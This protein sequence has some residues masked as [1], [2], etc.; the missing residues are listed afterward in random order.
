M[1]HKLTDKISKDKK[2]NF[3]MKSGLFVRKTLEEMPE[4]DLNVLFE[5]GLE[6]TE[7]KMEKIKKMLKVK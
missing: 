2:I 3:L 7:F 4:S 6:A 1:V 5:A